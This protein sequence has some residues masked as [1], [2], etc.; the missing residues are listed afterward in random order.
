MSEV[1]RGR[2]DVIPDL[3]ED[4][5]LRL[6]LKSILKFKTVSKQWRSI[7]ESRSFVES[8]MKV[9]KKP[10]ILA[11]G[12]H[13]SQSLFREGDTE[14]IDIVYINSRDAATRPSLT[15]DGLVCIP[16]P[17]WVNVLNPSTGEFVS[18]P[19]GPDPVTNHYDDNLIFTET[20][21][22]IF[23]AYW[24]MGVGRD[25]V[26]GSYKVVRMFFDPIPYC[27]IL[28]VDIGE[29]REVKPPPYKV[30]PRRK[31][32]FVNGSLYWIEMIKSDNV[33]ALDLHTEE[34]RDVVPFPPTCAVADQLV[35]LEDRLAIVTAYTKPWEFEIRVLDEQ[36]ETWSLVYSI[37]LANS[38]VFSRRQR[39][40]WFR[41]VAVSNS[42]NLFFHDNERT[43]CS[44]TTQR[45]IKS[46]ASLQTFV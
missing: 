6:P 21:W 12:D 38:G 17:G 39:S 31:P 29:W 1:Y 5:F 28:D 20:W 40:V 46:F 30:E 42:G 18:F 10:K 35:N 45:Q 15:C 27:E 33:F 26:S 9:Q 37:S 22:N 2:S 8:R 43:G 23:P 24:A 32:A 34:F 13:R 11:A 14:E 36:E 4:I 19:S 3:I 41:P 44:N 25:K 7:L 16:V